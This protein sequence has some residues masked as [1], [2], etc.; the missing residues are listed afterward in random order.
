MLALSNLLYG[1]FFFKVRGSCLPLPLVQ[2]KC[3]RYLP[4][5]HIFGLKFN[6]SLCTVEKLFYNSKYFIQAMLLKDVLL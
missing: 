5:I 1:K 3:C 6:Q 4:I 2:Q